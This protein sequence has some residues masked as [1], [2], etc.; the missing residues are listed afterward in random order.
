MSGKPVR[1]DG[2][3][4]TNGTKAEELEVVSAKDFKKILGYSF[5]HKIPLFVE[6]EAG[7]GKTRIVEDYCREN[8]TPLVVINPNTLDV[9]DVV[10][11]IP[12]GD[13]L[14]EIIMEGLPREGSGILFF[15]EFRQAPKENQRQFWRLFYQRKIGEYTL[16][17]GWSMAIASNLDEEIEMDE[18]EAPLF[19]RM[20][21]RCRYELDYTSWKEWAFENDLDV[22]VISYCGHFQ[23]HFHFK[24]T[25]G[26]A[27]T[28]PR[29][30]EMTSNALKNKAPEVVIRSILPP[31]ISSSFINYMK[32]VSMFESVE[33]YISGKKSAPAE[34]DRQYALACAIINK[35]V[36]EDF[37]EKA[38]RAEVKGMN[39]EVELF[40]KYGVIQKAINRKAK[41]T[42]E[43]FAKIKSDVVKK[44]IVDFTIKNGWLIKDD[45]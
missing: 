19:D 1:G 17:E 45:A 35:A 6:G 3:S 33:D 18:F 36:G 34:M 22:N 2:V 30:W 4:K 38:I 10:T 28:T 5:K 16:P 26:K 24:D 9:G 37:I 12:V 41:T 44:A 32:V 15:D 23:E 40:M 25:E 42:L 43:K 11:K 20:Q 7:I 21:I 8:N 27:I 31:A 14:K 39:K 29:R 13:K